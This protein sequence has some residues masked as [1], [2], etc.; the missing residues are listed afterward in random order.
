MHALKKNRPLRRIVLASAATV[1]GT[2]M[3]LSLKPH[4]SA[5]ATLVL[6]APA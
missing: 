4:T 5:Q 1:C 2:V 6:P 3:L